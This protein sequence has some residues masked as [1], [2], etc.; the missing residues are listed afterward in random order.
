MGNHH[1]KD[2]LVDDNCTFHPQISA[3]TKRLA[4]SKRRKIKEINEKKVDPYSTRRS[5]GTN[6]KRRKK[7]QFFDEIDFQDELEKFSFHH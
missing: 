7:S 6:K 2:C 5:I 1:K 4:E 3:R